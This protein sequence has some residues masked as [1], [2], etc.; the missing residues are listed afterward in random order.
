V[1]LAVRND[2]LVAGGSGAFEL[3]VAFVKQP[4]VVPCSLNMVNKYFL[5]LV[6]YLGYLSGNGAR[7][8]TLL[9]RFIFVSFAGSAFLCW[10]SS[11][12]LLIGP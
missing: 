11:G 4:E 1:D 10:H 6:S 7:L 8:V 9:M 3:D 12:S 2:A 5:N